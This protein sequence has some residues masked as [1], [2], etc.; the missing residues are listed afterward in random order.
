MSWLEGKVAFITGI[1]KGQGR[2][3]AVRLAREGAHIIGIDALKTYPWM[4]Y[5]LAEQSDVEETIG[6]VEAEGGR[7]FFQQADVTDLPSLKRAL[8]AGVAEFGR[9]DVV[10]A[11][12]G[13]FPK[14]DLTWEADPP[15]W[16]ECVEVNLFGVFHTVHAAVPHMVKAGNGGSII[17][18]SSGAA[19]VS[20]SYLSDYSASKAALLSLTRTLAVELA[21][22]WIRVNAICPGAVNTDMI[23]NDA[24]YRMFRPDLDAPT[25]EDT[26]EVWKSKHLLPVPWLEPSDISN[27]VAWLASDE[28]RLVTGVTLPVDAGNTIKHF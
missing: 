13:A 17:I 18:T 15:A 12:A 19:I 8:E 20:G 25:R 4:N 22:H 27:A 7:I 10:A 3:H 9:L 28:A 14:G 6:L 2:S 1:G 24:I 11:N 16:R 23:A 21:P 26:I 5:R